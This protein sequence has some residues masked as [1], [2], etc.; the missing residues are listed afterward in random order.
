MNQKTLNTMTQY[1]SKDIYAIFS[2]GFESGF[3]KRVGTSPEID[4]YVGRDDKG[5]YAFKYL[6]GNDAAVS[7]TAVTQGEVGAAS[8]IDALPIQVELIAVEAEGNIAADGEGATPLY[9]TLPDR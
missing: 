5:R 4:T 9:A 8:Y 7:V 3:F 2:E 6:T 1:N